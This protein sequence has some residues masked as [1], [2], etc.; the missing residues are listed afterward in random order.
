[1]V[2]RTEFF[3]LAVDAE[4]APQL[5]VVAEHIG[6]GGIHQHIDFAI[7]PGLFERIGHRRGQKH[8]AVVLQLDNQ[9]P[10]GRRNSVHKVCP[11]FRRPIFIEKRL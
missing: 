2:A 10:L 5:A 8:I 11:P 7:G 9:N 6:G 1:M 3:P 4:H